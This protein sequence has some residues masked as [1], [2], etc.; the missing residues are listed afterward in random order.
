MNFAE[1]AKITTPRV[2]EDEAI[3]I[4]LIEPVR[5]LISAQ[6]VEELDSVHEGGELDQILNDIDHS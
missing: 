3:C 6:K 4:H 5:G 1:M 2:Y